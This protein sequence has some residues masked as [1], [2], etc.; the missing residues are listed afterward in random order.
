MGHRV[1][2]IFIIDR[3]LSIG[4]HHIKHDIKPFLGIT[5]RK[6]RSKQRIG[7]ALLDRLPEASVYS[8]AALAAR[9]ARP[10]SIP[11][12]GG[13]TRPRPAELFS[14]VAFS[15][16]SSREVLPS[17][18]RT[19]VAFPTAQISTLDQT[20]QFVP[21]IAGKDLIRAIPIKHDGHVL[22]RQLRDCILGTAEESPKGSS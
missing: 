18:P 8:D 12:A 11:T 19:I 15:S 7:I 3:P 6:H 17:G 22:T 2:S 20:V 5:L 13:R 1:R 10:M 4:S 16:S 21:I 9:N 14:K